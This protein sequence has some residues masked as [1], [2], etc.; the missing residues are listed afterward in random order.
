MRKS[1]VI[2]VTFVFILSFQSACHAAELFEGLWRGF[3]LE[4]E[5][6]EGV[7]LGG[8][9]LY[10]TSVYEGVD[11]SVWAVPIIIGQY[12]RFYLDGSSLGYILNDREDLHFS[13][14][15]QLRFGG[16][17]DGDSS[18]LAGMDGREWSLDGGLRLTW[19]NGL[20]LLNITGITDLLGRHDGHEVRAIFSRNFLKGA[21]T[22]KLG[23]KWLS[24]NLVEYYYGVASSEATSARQVYEGG[25]TLDF[26]AGFSIVIPIG[27]NWVITGDFEYETLGSEIEDSPIVDADDTFRTVAGL[28]YRF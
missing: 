2:F 7:V 18:A 4:V 3:D 19:D 23:V 24:N 22:P 17:D 20:F 5:E 1:K 21:F 11:D 13:F 12:K 26:I 27:D 14:V 28:V 10:S 16:Y 15:M 8:G 9:V 6:L 25:S